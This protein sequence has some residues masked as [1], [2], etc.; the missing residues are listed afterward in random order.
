[1]MSGR[2]RLQ[3]PQTSSRVLARRAVGLF[4]PYRAAFALLF[5][6][7]VMSTVL[8][9]VGVRLLGAMVDQI[10]HLFDLGLFDRAPTPAADRPRLVDPADSSLPVEDR[11]RSYFDAN[12]GHCHSQGGFASDSAPAR[13]ERKIS[14]SAMIRSASPSS[15]GTTPGAV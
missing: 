11:V 12:C 15:P 14:S 5:T 8:D 1:M 7:L 3:R 13:S 9:L 10:D 6:L 2:H 4:R